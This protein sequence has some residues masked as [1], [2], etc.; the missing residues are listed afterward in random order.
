MPVYVFNVWLTD[1]FN[2]T[3]A[4]YT[5]KNNVINNFHPTFEKLNVS[6]F[7]EKYE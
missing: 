7:N 1:N 5:I 6:D 2:K 4:D 3:I